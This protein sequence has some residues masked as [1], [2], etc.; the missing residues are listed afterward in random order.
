MPDVR[1][2]TRLWSQEVAA[3]RAMD[4]LDSAGPGDAGLERLLDTQ[5]P[6]YE[7][8]NG[9]TFRDGKGPYQ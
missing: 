2:T 9:R 1:T 5:D 8:S 7:W 3:A 6:G 4:E